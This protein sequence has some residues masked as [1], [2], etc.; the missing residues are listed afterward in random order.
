MIVLRR[1]LAMEL[2]RLKPWVRVRIRGTD[3]LPVWTR[4]V[5]GHLPVAGRSCRAARAPRRRRRV[6]AP[7]VRGRARR[8]SSSSPVSRCSSR[9]STQSSR[10][11][12]RSTIRAA[13]RACRCDDG[14]VELRHVPVAVAMMV[15]VSIVGAFAAFLAGPSTEALQ[16]AAVCVLPAALGAVAGALVSVVGGAP[17]Q[18]GGGSWS[19]LPPEVAGMRLAFRTGFPPALAIVGHPARPRG[20][21]RGPQR[22]ACARPQPPRRASAC[23]PCS[24][25]SSVGFGFAVAS[26]LG[27]RRRWSWPVNG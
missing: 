7:A 23:W 15:M 21:C 14:W 17:S 10:S 24:C 20:A 6:S 1:Q 5:R 13:A 22:R 4:G 26:M 11:R 19:L 16:I 9:D 3:R 8:R 25:S 2:P 27:G 18:T 12:R